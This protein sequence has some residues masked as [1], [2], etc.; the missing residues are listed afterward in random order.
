MGEADIHIV[1]VLSF[2]TEAE[3][4]ALAVKMGLV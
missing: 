1:E 2:I 3:A 4:G